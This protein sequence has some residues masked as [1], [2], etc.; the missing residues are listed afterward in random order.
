M[1]YTFLVPD[2]TILRYADFVRALAE[3]ARQEFFPFFMS[4][5]QGMTK[6]RPDAFTV[7]DN[8]FQIIWPENE[9][10]SFI[11]ILESQMSDYPVEAANITP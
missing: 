9:K 1:D 10:R 8:D 7:D 11:E 3:Q 6:T 5:F 2:A 4:Y